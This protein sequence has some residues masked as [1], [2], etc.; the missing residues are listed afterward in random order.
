MGSIV[1]LIAMTLTA[2]LVP[3]I[4][5]SMP[6]LNR[7]DVIARRAAKAQLPGWVSLAEFV[8]FIASM[9]VILPLFFSIENHAHQF[10]H[11]GRSM[12]GSI[13]PALSPDLIFFLIQIL[14]PLIM[15]MPFGMLLANLLSWLIPPIRN[16]EYKTMAEGV[17][18]YNWHDLN[19]GLI[20]AIIIISPVCIILAIISLIQL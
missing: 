4:V 6:Y 5:G 3:R 9:A 10:F 8:F 12:L 13:Q 7:K 14:T 16:I 20:K 19:F 18:G 15:A 17:P 1:S 2:I 11:H